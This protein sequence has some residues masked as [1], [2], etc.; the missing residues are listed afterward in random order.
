MEQ[1]DYEKADTLCAYIVKNEGD[2][3]IDQKEWLN[4]YKELYS[5][6]N[7][8]P[9]NLPAI[10]N[11]NFNGVRYENI[12]TFHKIYKR[13]LDDFTILDTKKHSEVLVYFFEEL[14]L[15]MLVECLKQDSYYGMD[16][17]DV[18]YL[19]AVAFTEMQ[20]RGNLK[21]RTVS[22]ACKHCC[23][24]QYFFIGE[25]DGSFFDLTFV[26]EN[27]KVIDI[28]ECQETKCMVPEEIK[29]EKRIFINTNLNPF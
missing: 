28:Y 26:L 6:F 29:L 18:I 2:R 12:A 13:T 23:R 5:K 16:Y 3:L 27:D 14:N 1:N 9:N 22:W 7:I 21:T 4:K 25:K 11:C 17:T 19:L 15:S 24:Q 10:A 8:Q 20:F